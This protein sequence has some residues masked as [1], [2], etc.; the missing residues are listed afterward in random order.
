MS[1]SVL[2]SDHR[3][4]IGDI[5]YYELAILATA[6]LANASATAG[7]LLNKLR[8]ARVVADRHLPRDVVRIGSRVHFTLEGADPATT[9]LDFPAEALGDP[10]RTS[11][12][13]R[14]GAT[15]LG[16]QAGQWAQLPSR[17]TPGRRLQVTQVEMPAAEPEPALPFADSAALAPAP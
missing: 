15:L 1:H 12:L 10:D 2:T 13:S 8:H 4:A 9:I 11:V 16:L 6:D 5:D 14:L 17:G 7:F 3:V